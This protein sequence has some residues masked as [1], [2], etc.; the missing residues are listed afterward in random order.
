MDGGFIVFGKC[1]V[2]LKLTFL[3]TRGWKWTTHLLKEHIGEQYC[4]WCFRGCDQS[5]LGL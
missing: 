4:V 5:L 2:Q 1:L 3:M